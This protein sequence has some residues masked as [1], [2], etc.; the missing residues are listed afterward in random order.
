ML[1]NYS[2]N[3]NKFM[4]TIQTIWNTEKDPLTGRVETRTDVLGTRLTILAAAWLQ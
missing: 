4:E 1:R 3:S 2:L